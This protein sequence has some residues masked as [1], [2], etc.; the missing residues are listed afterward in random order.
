MVIKEFKSPYHITAAFLCLKGP[1][2]CCGPSLP[3][4]EVHRM[5][6]CGVCAPMHHHSSSHALSLPSLIHN[7]CMLWWGALELLTGFYCIRKA[8]RTHQEV[9]LG[10]SESHFTLYR[11]VEFY[12]W[13]NNSPVLPSQMCMLSTAYNVW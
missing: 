10:A 9:L 3:Y 6:T 13:K 7:H 5:D 4:I 2:A 11:A 12:K 1:M 8:C